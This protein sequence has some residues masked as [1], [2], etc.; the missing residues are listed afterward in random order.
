MHRNHITQRKTADGLEFRSAAP[1]SIEVRADGDVTG[2]SGHA[3]TFMVA[4]SYWTAFAKGAFRKS[5]KDRG[6]RLPFLWQ[7]NPDFGTIGNHVAIKEDPKGLFVDVDLIDDGDRG[8][9]ALKQL[10]GNGKLGLSFGFQTLKDR[11][12]EDDD[13]IDLSQLSKGAKKEDIRVIT[14]VR[15]WETSLVTF[16]ANEDAIPAA[17]RS[18]IKTD[19]ITT[20][21]DAI[22]AGHLTD[23]EYAQIVAAWQAR[24]G[25]GAGTDHSTPTDAK[26]RRRQAVDIALALAKDRGLLS[27]VPQ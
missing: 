18:Q 9:V 24:D 14:E 10:R 23:A 15:L 13:E 19:A 21:M 7:H 17:L 16:P 12:A 6:D 2:F 5:V 22:R 1:G 20:L 3:A 4:D 27:G 11:T 25:A 26:A 8:S